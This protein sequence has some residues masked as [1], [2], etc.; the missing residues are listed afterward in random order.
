[1]VRSVCFLVVLGLVWGP[2]AGSAQETYAIKVKEAGKGERHKVEKRSKAK[3]TVKVA[4]GQGNPL[5]VQE[6]DKVERFVYE[7]TILEKPEGLKKPSRLRRHYE[8]AQ[9]KTGSDTQTLRFHGKTVDIRKKDDGYHFRIE[10]GGELSGKDAEFLD[11]EF[12][13]N[14][15]GDFDFNKAMLPKKPVRVMESWKLDAPALIEDLRKDTPF[16]IDAANTKT[17]ATLVKAYKKDGRQF[18]V[19]KLKLVFPIKGMKMAEM[20][21]R[22][23]EGATLT[24]EAT[25][26]GCI[27]GTLVEGNGVF[28]GSMTARADLDQAGQKFRLTASM[29]MDGEEKDK[30]LGKK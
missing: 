9:V 10:G 3:L 5:H 29:S 6:E 28:K 7:E 11:K 17:S 25:M 30:E 24:M 16:E 14:K 2:G 8:V 23:A 21:V 1:M 19:V 18:G 26:D 20:K 27:D 13:K 4:D 12:N 22:F 15:G